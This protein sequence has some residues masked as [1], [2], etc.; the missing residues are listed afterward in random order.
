MQESFYLGKNSRGGGWGEAL[1]R[2]WVEGPSGKRMGGRRRSRRSLQLRWGGAQY[3]SE[4]AATKR[5]LP[6]LLPRGPPKMHS[7]SRSS[8][9][10]SG[11]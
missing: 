8:L 5:E 7:G 2:V 11:G 3:L 10:R 4:E 1:G 9:E 6:D